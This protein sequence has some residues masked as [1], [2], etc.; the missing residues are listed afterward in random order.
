MKRKDRGC[1][2]QILSF[3]FVDFNLLFDRKVF[4]PEIG[5]GNLS[6]CVI[7]A[8]VNLLP[9]LDKSGGG[10]NGCPVTEFGSSFC[11]DIER[12]LANDCVSEDEDGTG[13]GRRGSYRGEFDERL[14]NVFEFD[15]IGE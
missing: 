5:A 9:R 12:E 7:V 6:V 3:F 1:E 11:V 10:G 8:V 13:N 2:G 14:L 15:E 4:V